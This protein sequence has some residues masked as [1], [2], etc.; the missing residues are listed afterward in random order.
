[1]RRR[2]LRRS[3]ARSTK[4]AVERIEGR[5]LLATFMVTNTNDDTNMG[6]LRFAIGQ[7]NATPG[8]NTIQFSI[9]NSG[10]QTISLLSALPAITV[11]VTIDGTT[12]G[13]YAGKP[14][15]ELNGAGAG[16]AVDGLDISAGNTTVKGLAINRF[17]GEGISLSVAGTDTITKDFLG[18]DPTGTIAEGNKLDGLLVQFNSNNNTITGNLISGNTNNG[19]Y[20][21][22]Q[23]FGMNNPATSGNLITGNLI[24]TDIT[25]TVVV[26]NGEDGVYVQNAPMTTI[27]GTTPAARNVLSGNGTGMELYDN[28][29]GS[30]IEGNYIGTDITGS[31]A[32]GNNGR[33][34]SSTTISS[35]GGS[36][37]APSAGQ[38][39]V[40][41]T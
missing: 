12:E 23:S 33:M 3:S 8:A 39:P 4:L 37:T 38:R 9:A 10:V 22:G 25:G 14:L 13:G 19:I 31:V 6:S 29:D 16:T 34:G 28:S 32:L 35:S 15:I 36:P 30:V 21:N 2:S 20:L 40:P 17:T 7:S 11:P 26:S 5:I 24:G 1:M 41:A 27:G 18:T